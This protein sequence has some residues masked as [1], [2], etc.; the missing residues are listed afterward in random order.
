MPSL[1][2]GILLCADGSDAATPIFYGS[3]AT[4][5]A[6]APRLPSGQMQQRQEQD[7]DMEVANL[8]YKQRLETARARIASKIGHK[9]T[10]KK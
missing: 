10:V 5:P 7:C 6:A 3:G 9:V 1:D 2:A 4:A 8:S